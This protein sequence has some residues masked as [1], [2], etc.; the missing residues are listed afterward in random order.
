[1][2]FLQRIDGLAAPNAK[3]AN[4]HRRLFVAASTHHLWRR[5]QATENV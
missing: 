2:A 5:Y 1:M 4:I 3:I